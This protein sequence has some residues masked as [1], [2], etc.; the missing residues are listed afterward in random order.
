MKAYIKIDNSNQEE[1]G[2]FLSADSERISVESFVNHKTIDELCFDLDMTYTKGMKIDMNGNIAIVDKNAKIEYEEKP[3]IIYSYEPFEYIINIMKMF[4]DK[5]SKYL[6]D[7]F[8]RTIVKDKK[9]DKEKIYKNILYY[10]CDRNRELTSDMV[11]IVGKFMTYFGFIRNVYDDKKL[12]NKCNVFELMYSFYLIYE[13]F[14]LFKRLNNFMEELPLSI[15]KVMYE[16][17]LDNDIIDKIN[18]NLEYLENIDSFSY[19]SEFDKKNVLW[20]TD[21]LFNNSLSLVIYELRMQLSK[22]DDVTFSICKNPACL[23]TIVVTNGNQLYCTNN[24]ECYRTREKQRQKVSRDNK[25][26]IKQSKT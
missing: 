17:N 24:E 13:T 22:N 26:K 2:K 8:I 23:K 15:Y 19:H 18:Y 1:L 9:L 20:K 21:L 4:D 7:N 25:K 12:T 5:I 10:I 14:Y 6:D 16:K 11:N 3:K